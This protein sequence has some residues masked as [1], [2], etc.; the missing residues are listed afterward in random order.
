MRFLINVYLC[1]SHGPADPW[2]EETDKRT[3]VPRMK[4]GR[5]IKYTADGGDRAWKNDTL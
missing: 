3:K 5:V 4:D 2:K 1:E